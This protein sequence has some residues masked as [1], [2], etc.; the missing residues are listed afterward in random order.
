LKIKSASGAERKELRLTPFRMMC[1]REHVSIPTGYRRL[2]TGKWRAKKIDGR[3]Y[4]EDDSVEEL[5]QSAPSYQPGH[6]VSRLLRARE[7]AAKERAASSVTA[8]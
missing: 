4:V 6:G 7:R 1:K 2:N 3:T 5:K 8:D